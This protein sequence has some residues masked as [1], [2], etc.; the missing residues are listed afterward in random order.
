MANIN[1]SSQKRTFAIRNKFI[2]LLTLVAFL[3]L[4]VIS[5]AATKYT[6]NNCSCM[7]GKQGTKKCKNSGDSWNNK[8]QSENSTAGGNGG[9]GENGKNGANGKNGT[10][11]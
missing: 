6:T 10:N 7:S 3:S 11:G 2:C 1:H 9:A 8:K 5:M 4:P